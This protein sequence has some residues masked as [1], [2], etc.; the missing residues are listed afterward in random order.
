MTVNMNMKILV[1][2]DFVGTRQM[3]MAALQTLGLRNIV[4]VETAAH[5][6]TKMKKKVFDFII[7]DWSMPEMSGLDLLKAV[8]ADKDISDTP[9]FMITAESHADKRNEATEAGVTAY[10]ITP[11]SPQVLKEAMVEVFGEFEYD[12]LP[13]L[14][15][16]INL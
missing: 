3:I 1:V 9:F 16:P 8:R 2:D 5:A 12:L 7:S 15:R 4:A 11:I 6:L 13:S 14:N 10:M